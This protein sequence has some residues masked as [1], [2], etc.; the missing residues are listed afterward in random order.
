[1][2]GR[3][4]WQCMHYRTAPRSPVLAATRAGPLRDGRNLRGGLEGNGTWL[5]SIAPAN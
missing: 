3:V 4:T 1:M 5:A 2:D